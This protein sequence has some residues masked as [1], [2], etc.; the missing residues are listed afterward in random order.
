M[1]VNTAAGN[2]D[3]DMGMPVKPPSVAMKGAENIDIQPPLPGSV[4]QVIRCQATEVVKSPAVDFKEWSE[5][6]GQGE[7]QMLPVAVW[8]L[9]KLRGYPQVGGFFTAGR[10]GPAVA[11]VG[12]VPDVRA[13]RVVAVI[14]LHAADAGAAGQHFGDGFDFDIAQAAGGRRLSAVVSPR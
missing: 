8:Q 5:R 12:D 4:Q 6:V 14:L 9:V 3:V 2:G 7:D 11:G 10:T 13:L 1:P